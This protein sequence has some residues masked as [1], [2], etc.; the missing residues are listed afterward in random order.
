VGTFWFIQPLKSECPDGPTTSSDCQIQKIVENVLRAFALG[1]NGERHPS[2]S[3]LAELGIRK[4]YVGQV[5]GSDE[6]APRST[7]TVPKKRSTT[8]TSVRPAPTTTRAAPA[9]PS[10][11]A[12]PPDTTD[13][14]NTP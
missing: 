4:G 14:S 6:D 9:P 10:T 7:T 5:G 3:N 13:P 1:P 11:T 2:V 8:T 12:E